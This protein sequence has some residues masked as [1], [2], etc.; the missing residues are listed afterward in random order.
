M[1][2]VILCG[3]LGT[4]M[5]EETEF[6]PKPM[7]EVGGRPVL[8]HI[9]K[10]YAHYGIDD[11]V[12]CTGYKGEMIKEYFLNYEARNNDFTIQLGSKNEIEFHNKH[13]ESHWKVTVADTGANT[14]TAGRLKR[15]QQYVGDEAF[16][17]TYGDGVA[18]V[19][20]DA[21][22]KQHKD[23]GKLATV[24][25]V[26][27]PSRFGLM[28]ADENNNVTQFA[29]KATTDGWVNGGFFVFEPKVFDYMEQD[30]ML[31][32]D[33]MLN[34]TKD[35]QLNAYQ[36]HGFWQPM[37]TFRESTML[38]EMWDSGNAPWKVWEN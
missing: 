12:L 21:L 13:D 10:I 8:W 33:P 5:R 19:K 26:Q 15:V 34:L 38:N 31:E 25:S 22:L 11:F 6:R 4:R 32:Q 7:V 18:D 9:M 24:T 28:E 16:C 35:G 20:I 17:V 30:V 37:D 23:S 27:I 2:A 36:H 29:E 3:G 14:M 1:K